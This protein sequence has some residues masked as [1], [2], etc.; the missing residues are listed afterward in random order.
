MVAAAAVLV[1]LGVVR[2][3]NHRLKLELRRTDAANQ[4]TAATQQELHHTRTQEMAE[5]L[6]GDLRELAAVPLTIATLVE[7][8][9]DWDEQ[10]L[11][12]ALKNMLGKAPLIFGLC[13]AFE[14]YQ[15]RADRENFAYYVFR[16]AG[17]LAVKRLL[18]P[19]YLP[20][21]RD[22]PWYRA[23][24]QACQGRWGEPYIGEGADRTPM[25]TYSA[26]IRRDGKFVGVV[27]A[28]LAMDYFR[29]LRS[30]LG[31]LDTGPTSYCF[32]VSDAG[33]I[34]A[35]PDDRYEFPGIDSDLTKVPV[36]ASFRVMVAAGSVPRRERPGPS[37]SRPAGRPCF[38]AFAFR[39]QTGCL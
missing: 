33:R 36:D 27:T 6:D 9:H 24:R 11:D 31:P 35:H 25:V 23:A 29:N 20:L 14:P 30:S 7:N 22:W 38:A 37:T 3:Y 5:R 28:D 15:W 18:P 12:Q 4:E 16:R 26:P 2:T 39:R 34:L 10:H 17:G 8:R 13:V 1:V 19:E 32:L 21:Y